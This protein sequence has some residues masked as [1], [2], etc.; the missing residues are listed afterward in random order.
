MYWNFVKYFI[1]SSAVTRL[2]ETWDVL[3]CRTSWQ[4]ATKI[5]RINRNMRCIEMAVRAVRVAGLVWLI[6]TWDVL[7]SD[8]LNGIDNNAERL[9]ETWDVLKCSLKLSSSSI[10]CGLIETWDVLK[11]FLRRHPSP[12][13]IRLIETWDV[14]KYIVDC[15]LRCLTCD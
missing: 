14:L 13:R 11:C 6:E 10:V 8:F 5:L 4:N 9:I 2:I 1:R 15:F 3:K 12:R 7:K